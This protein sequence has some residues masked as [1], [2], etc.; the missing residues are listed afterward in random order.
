MNLK[1]RLERV[2]D[3]VDEINPGQLKAVIQGFVE[4]PETGYAR[5]TLDPDDPRLQQGVNADGEAIL[6]PWWMV[7][8]LE[9]T[10]EQQEAR[11]K[12]LKADPTYRKPS[13]NNGPAVFFEGAARCDDVFLRLH[14][15]RKTKVSGERLNRWYEIAS[16]LAQRIPDS[17][18]IS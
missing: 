13:M 10:W 17:S 6:S 15:R 4:G 16:R 18:S 14:E 5:G 9:G 12:E 3:R 8:F 1:R 2:E 7:I 11:L